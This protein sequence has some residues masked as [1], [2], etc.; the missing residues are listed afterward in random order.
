MFKRI[1]SF[2]AMVCSLGKSGILLHKKKGRE[3]GSCIRERKGEKRG[4]REGRKGGSTGGRER[5][6]EGG[7]RWVGR[8][9]AG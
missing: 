4:R 2:K 6:R 1:K 3:K 9:Q 5:E 8:R 7:R